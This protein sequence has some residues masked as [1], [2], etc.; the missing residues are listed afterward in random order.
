MIRLISLLLVMLFISC[1]E[2]KQDRLSR[3]VNEWHGKVIHFPDSMC[4]AS[5]R[6]DTV[7]IKYTRER[8]SYTILN[9]VDTVGCF[10]CRLKL[11]RWKEM[12][13]NLDS[14]YPNKVKCLMVFY[15]KGEK[16]LIKHLRN[17]NFGIA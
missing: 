9:Y 2:S 13:S 14:I 12:I 15:P 4:L 5:Y 10:S 11:P 17:S 1:K 3:I 8:S 7:I 16:K 6:S